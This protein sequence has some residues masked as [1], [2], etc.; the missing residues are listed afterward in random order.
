MRLF[1]AAVPPVEVLEH[2]ELALGAVRGPGRG[3]LRWTE[4]GDRHL[5]L[6]FYGE[7]P[8]GYLDE[9]TRALDDVAGTTAP[10]KLALRGAGVFD[11]RTVWIGLAGD[12]VTLQALMGRAA[13]MGTL[14]R[15]DP[16]HRSRAHVTVARARGRRGGR[17]AGAG[18]ADAAA[19]AHALAVY[20]GPGWTVRDVV[21]MAS[22][23]GT[24]RGGAPRY[25]VVHRSP[26]A[27]V[28]G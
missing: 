20:E 23:L 19:L 18:P 26:L 5:T 3:P 17:G 2:L 6:A 25:D 22:D 10:F 27:A 8:E 11:G 16:D 12:V 24:G 7:V 21:L 9:F 15:R 4:P 1:A 28:A 14:L 13:S